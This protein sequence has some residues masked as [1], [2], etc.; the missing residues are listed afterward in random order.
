M[1]IKSQKVLSYFQTYGT[2][3]METIQC[4]GGRMAMI[5]ALGS[6]SQPK[7]DAL[8]DALCS[9][10]GEYAVRACNAAS[11]VSAQP[12]GLLEMFCGAKRRA[13]QAV[14]MVPEAAFGIGIESGMFSFPEV[15]IESSAEYSLMC[16]APAI[17]VVNRA[18]KVISWSIGESMPLPHSLA[19]DAL[20][21]ELGDA[22]IKRGQIDKDPVALLTTGSRHW[23]DRL[24]S[25]LCSALLPA[26]HRELYEG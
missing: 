25:A 6:K 26:L 24:A 1:G 10:E 19:K 14:G 23:R 18:A 17:V 13:Q 20:Q 3:S 12:F 16:D 11:D 8:R 15:P 9:F 2:I 22:V 21:S 5:I 4:R 7:I